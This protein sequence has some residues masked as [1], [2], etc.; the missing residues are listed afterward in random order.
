MFAKYLPAIVAAGLT[1][2]P[3][4]AQTS[5]ISGSPHF[6]VV[7][8]RP[9]EK[10]S[11]VRRHSAGRI[12][13]EGIGIAELII[14][15]FGGREYQIE[16]PKWVPHFLNILDRTPRADLDFRFYTIAATFPPATTSEE[17][18]FMLQ[19]ML[20][21]RFHLVTHR[22]TKELPLYEVTIAQSGIGI[23]ESPPR[24]A[25]PGVAEDDEHFEGVRHSQKVSFS[26]T[27]MHYEGDYTIALLATD[28]TSSLP[29]PVVDGTGLSK[30]YVVDFFWSW[31]PY[32]QP[33]SEPG[34]P[35]RASA[36][37]IQEL[38]ATMNKKLGLKVELHRVPTE[39]IVIDQL[40]RVPSEN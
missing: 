11:G 15:A 23:H 3:A 29:Y 32:S 39:V 40:D 31:N 25:V 21:E 18:Q 36:P 12:D 22:E 37:Y 34:F 26:E 2:I 28:L 30:Y 38:I 10:P 19:E 35:N 1:V 8:V 17:L 14:K 27:G 5:A 24:N 16:F 9:A 13:Y 4:F 20:R 6:D 33:P 7:S